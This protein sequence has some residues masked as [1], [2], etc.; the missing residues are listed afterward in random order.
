MARCLSTQT[1]KYTTLC[2]NLNQTGIRRVKYSGDQLHGRTVR[3]IGL[4]N[5]LIIEQD[6]RNVWQLI[7]TTASEDAA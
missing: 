7:Q 6:L 4:G 3:Q 2:L 5:L 1:T